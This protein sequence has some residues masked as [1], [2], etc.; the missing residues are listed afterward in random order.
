[1][2]QVQLELLWPAAQRFRVRYPIETDR[3]KPAIIYRRNPLAR[4]YRLFVDREGRP[5][6]TIPRRGNHR[7]AEAFAAKHASWLLEQLRRHEA[8]RASTQLWEVGTPILFRGQLTPIERHT[9]GPAGSIRIGSEVIPVSS[10]PGIVQAGLRSIIESHLRR[11]ASIELPERTLQLAAAYNSPVRTITIR[12]QRSRWGSCS[13]RGTISL[14][15]RLVQVPSEV[16][17]YI[18]LHELMHLRE[19]NHSRRFWALVAKACPDYK[20]SEAWL[21]AH[22]ASLL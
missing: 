7:E 10:H 18:I 13:R 8:R 19:M 17:D 5:R 16:R 21:R 9:D 2:K 4:R 1:V 14:N 11:L 6:V 20:L 15:W 22:S 3:D 12:N